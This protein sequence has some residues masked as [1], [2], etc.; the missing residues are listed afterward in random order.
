MTFVGFDSIKRYTET[1]IDR[2][3][4]ANYRPIDDSLSFL[5]IVSHDADK[6]AIEQDVEFRMPNLEV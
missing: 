6:R 3:A 4:A 1:S 5:L 2:K